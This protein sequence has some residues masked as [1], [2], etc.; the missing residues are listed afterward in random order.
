MRKKHQKV[1][2]WKGVEGGKEGEPK[3]KGLEGKVT[4]A[5][6]IFDKEK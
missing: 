4:V 2:I 1:G 6:K 5:R 3:G